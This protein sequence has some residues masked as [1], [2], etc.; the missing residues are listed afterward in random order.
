MEKKVYV[1]LPHSPDGMFPLLRL[2]QQCTRMLSM[3]ELACKRAF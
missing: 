2:P 3:Y 1:E